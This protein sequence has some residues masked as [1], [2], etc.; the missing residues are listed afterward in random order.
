[1]VNTFQFPLPSLRTEMLTFEQEAEAV[2][3]YGLV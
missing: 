1:M 3:R 2:K